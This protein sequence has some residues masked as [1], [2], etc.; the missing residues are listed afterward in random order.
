MDTSSGPFSPP[1][2][3]I[4]ASKAQWI[5]LQYILSS[6]SDPNAVDLSFVMR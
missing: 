5:E 6:K 4:E 2:P 1:R 3:M